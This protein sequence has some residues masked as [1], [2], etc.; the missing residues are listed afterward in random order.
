MGMRRRF[1]VQPRWQPRCDDDGRGV[2]W[3]RRRGAL[4]ASRSEKGRAP[5][6]NSRRF[7]S[8]F[9]LSNAD[10]RVFPRPTRAPAE[11]MAEA[12]AQ[13]MEVAAGRGLPFNG[14]R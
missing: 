7:G 14:E 4:G 2:R 11:A 5:A 8:S 10:A 3:E 6:R 12:P 9:A 1:G 13:A